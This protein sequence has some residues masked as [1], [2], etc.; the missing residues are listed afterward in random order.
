MEEVTAGQ[1]LHRLALLEVLE[2]DGTL[3]TLPT[4]NARSKAH[5]NL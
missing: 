2:A 4:L 3:L 1:S 5:F